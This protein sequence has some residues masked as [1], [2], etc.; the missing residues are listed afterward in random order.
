MF[1]AQAHNIETVCLM[2]NKGKVQMQATPGIANLFA[3]S[4]LGQTVASV[5]QEF[6]AKHAGISYKLYILFKFMFFISSS[7]L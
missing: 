7:E 2:L 6:A 1:Q 4:D 3:S 5:F